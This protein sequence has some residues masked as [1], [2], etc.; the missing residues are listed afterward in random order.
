MFRMPKIPVAL[1]SSVRSA[2][3]FLIESCAFLL[4][5]CFPSSFIVPDFLV[6]IPKI[7][8]RVSVR[9]LPSSPAIPRISPFLA[10]KE[11]SFRIEY[12][13]ERCST[14]SA[15]SPGLFVFGGN[16]LVSSRP[17]IRRMISSISRSSA[18][19]VATQVPSRM[20]VISSEI[21]LISAILCEM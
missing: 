5:T 8:S 16:W 18:F 19:S 12:I 1:L 17:T 6:A 20:I 7:V 11:T 10:L 4:L 2:N 15:T 21:R 14:S 3:P 9:P 13:P